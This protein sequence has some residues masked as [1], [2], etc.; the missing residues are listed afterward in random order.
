MKPLSIRARLTLWH[1]GVLA[2]IV[3][4]FALGVFLYVGTRVQRQLDEQLTKDLS[5]IEGTYR[6]D[7]G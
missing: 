6:S 1:T 4:V 5:A 2:S 7:P 3:V